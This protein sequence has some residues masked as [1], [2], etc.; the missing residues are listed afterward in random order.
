MNY[1]FAFV[2]YT[3]FQRNNFPA[4]IDLHEIINI[5]VETNENISITI[6]TSET[7]NDWNSEKREAA[8]SLPALTDF[9]DLQ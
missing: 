9:Y 3:Y 5:L 8:I 4:I 7:D 1:V 2:F 6:R